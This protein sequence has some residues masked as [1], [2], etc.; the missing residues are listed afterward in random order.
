MKKKEAKELCILKWEFI[1]KNNGKDNDDDN[2]RNI[3]NYKR[4]RRYT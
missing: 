2:N 3:K 1:V 4:S